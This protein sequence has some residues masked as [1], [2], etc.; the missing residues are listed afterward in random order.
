MVN[1][2]TIHHNTWGLGIGEY[3][4]HVIYLYAHVSVQ[5][6]ILFVEMSKQSF[7]WTRDSDEDQSEP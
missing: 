2:I 7:H 5:K 6:T 3:E 1:G 4:F